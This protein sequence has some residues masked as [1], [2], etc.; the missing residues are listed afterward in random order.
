M[1]VVSLA[2]PWSVK[3]PPNEI[4]AELLPSVNDIWLFAK[5]EFEIEGNVKVE[6]PSEAICIAPDTPLY[7][8]SLIVDS[9]VLLVVPLFPS[10]TKKESVSLKDEIV[11]NCVTVKSF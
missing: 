9:K 6:V 5:F 11:S 8:Y 10:S 1:T 7:I 2:E 4:F 3:V